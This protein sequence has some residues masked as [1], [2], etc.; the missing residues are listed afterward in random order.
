MN[1]GMSVRAGDSISVDM[2]DGTGITR[3][4]TFTVGANDLTAPPAWWTNPATNNGSAFSSNAGTDPQEEWS[5][6]A[7]FMLA[8]LANE[9]TTNNPNSVNVDASIV[10]SAWTGALPGQQGYELLL[11]STERGVPLNVDFTDPKVTLAGAAGQTASA[12]TITVNFTREIK[13]GD[14]LTLQG[15]ANATDPQHLIDDGN[16]VG[17]VDNRFGSLYDY[18]SFANG[19]LINS[20]ANLA[21][22]IQG[23]ANI[24]TAVYTPTNAADLSQGGQL[25]ITANTNNVDDQPVL[26]ASESDTNGEIVT[27]PT[28]QTKMVL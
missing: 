23:D 20:N 13:A 27:N 14:Q 5:E 22:A 8:G 18:G 24:L 19:T 7:R 4:F 11:R 10:P 12:S 17:E 6:A 2:D 26:T 15:S 25:V 28:N 16:P 1:T 3:T 9:I 21:A